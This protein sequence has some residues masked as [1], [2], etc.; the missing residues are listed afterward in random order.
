[1]SIEKVKNYFD[2]YHMKERIIELEQSS[3]TVKEA[4]DALGCREGEIAKTLSFQLSD[5]V[6]LIVLAG[7]VKL[8]N[9]KFKEIFHE[10]ANML[11]AMLVEEK[12]G[13]Q[14]GGVCPFGINENVDVYLDVSL[15]K[16]TTVYPACGN[17]HSAIP[18]SIAEME[19]Y[20]NYKEWIDVSKPIE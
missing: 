18:I 19:Q 2:K 1:M 12:V 17:N 10:R 3:A 4:A 8:D 20:S 14:V 7:D 15:K 11:E 6:I 9:R 16:Y 5:R 13:H